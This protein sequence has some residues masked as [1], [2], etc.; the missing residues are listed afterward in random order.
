MY[1]FLK[2]YGFKPTLI[3]L[4]THYNIYFLRKYVNIKEIENFSVLNESDYDILIVNS[5]QCWL[6]KLET[7]KTI[8]DMGFLSFAK[9]WNIK[10][11]VYAASLGH[12]YWN[13]SRFWSYFSS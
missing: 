10:K 7:K 5:D 9:N 4:K 8:L 11:F 6:Y 2:K 1:A 3:S 13:I 12:S